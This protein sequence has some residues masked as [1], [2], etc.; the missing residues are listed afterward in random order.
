MKALVVKKA[1]RVVMLNRNSTLIATS[2]PLTLGDNVGA[3]V[4]VVV[5]AVGDVVGDVVG[6]AV[7]DVV[8]DVVGDWVGDMVG[9]EVCDV[10]GDCIGD[11]VG[12]VVGDVVGDVGRPLFLVGDVVGLEVCAV[13][14]WAP[15]MAS[16]VKSTQVGMDVRGWCWLDVIVVSSQCLQSQQIKLPRRGDTRSTSI[17]HNSHSATDTPAT[18]VE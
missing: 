13:V 15:M 17:K 14:R 18:R 3:P 10:V 9:L 1:G 5:G 8:G 11:T 16:A 6:L 2:A 4:G 7:G 12:L